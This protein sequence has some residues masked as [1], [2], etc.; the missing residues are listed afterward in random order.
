MTNPLLGFSSRETHERS[1]ERRRS[2]HSQI[3]KLSLR[4]GYI[5][6]ILYV[7][8]AISSHRMDFSKV[9]NSGKFWFF[10]SCNAIQG[11]VSLQQTICFSYDPG[12]RYPESWPFAIPGSL[13]SVTDICASWQE[14]G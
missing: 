10:S 13:R 14:C 3:H 1:G 2:T 7:V 4:K 9:L 12:A 8:T 6:S 11:G 5:S